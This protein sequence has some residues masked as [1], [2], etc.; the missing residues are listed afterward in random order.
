MRIQRQRSA[1]VE[2]PLAVTSTTGD[3]TVDQA[4]G[5]EAVLLAGGAGTRLRAVSGEVP[6]PLCEVAGRPFVAHLLGQ[7]REAGVARC[8][9]CTGYR[10]DQVEQVLGPSFGDSLRLDYSREPEPLG[11]AGA[12]RH[13]LGRLTAETL[14]VMNAD[15]YVRTPLAKFVE[16][17]RKHAFPAALIAVRLA[18]A[19]SFGRLAIDP[20]TQRLKS[21]GEKRAT[22]GSAWVNAGVYLLPRSFLSDIPAGRFVSIEHESFPRWAARGYVGAYKIGAEFTDIGTPD[23]LSGARKLMAGTA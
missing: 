9:V 14:L 1:G 3:S 22:S 7:L 4:Q 13:A 8:L 17:H 23:R 21:F 11:T 20:V 16:W 10:G 12:L 6:K 18:D 15:S 2:K 19:S 5:I